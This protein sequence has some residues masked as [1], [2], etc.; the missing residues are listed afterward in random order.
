MV[1]VMQVDF[2]GIL[3]VIKVGNRT[4]ITPRNTGDSRGILKLWCR[5]ALSNNYSLYFQY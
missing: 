4:P 2:R 3:K 1:K 5:R